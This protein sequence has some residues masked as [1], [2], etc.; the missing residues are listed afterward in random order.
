M[1]GAMA[2]FLI[3]AVCIIIAL[4][5]YCAL[6]LREIDSNTKAIRFLL[7]RDYDQDLANRGVYPL[8]KEPERKSKSRGS[9]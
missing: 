7:F 8:S 3:A 1:V 6:L 2:T 5:I 4:L 9:R